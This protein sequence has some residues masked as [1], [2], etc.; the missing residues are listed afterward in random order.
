MSMS[1]PPYVSSIRITLSEDVAKDVTLAT[2]MKSQPGVADVVVV[3]EELSAYVKVD[4]KQTNR[5]A[6]EAFVSQA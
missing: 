4:T 6:L 1:E 5:Q 2:R 3:A